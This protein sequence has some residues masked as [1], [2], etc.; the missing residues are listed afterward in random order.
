[1][2]TQNTTSAL[3]SYRGEEI[4]GLVFPF[5]LRRINENTVIPSG[6]TV[7]GKQKFGNRSRICM[8][9][10]EDVCP[11]SPKRILKEGEFYVSGYQTNFDQMKKIEIAKIKIKECFDKDNSENHY[12]W[13]MNC[14]KNRMGMNALPTHEIETIV[15][16]IWQKN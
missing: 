5:S 13:T 4:L 8:I 11:L 12:K 10:N 9:K 16:E 6:Y 7:I 2:K 1:M 3:V 15:N 14:A